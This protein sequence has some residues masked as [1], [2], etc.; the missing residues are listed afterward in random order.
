ME[1]HNGES[2]GIIKLKWHDQECPAIR[3]CAELC[4]PSPLKQTRAA[5]CIWKAKEGHAKLKTMFC[6]CCCCCCRSFC[7]CFCCCCPLLELGKGIRYSPPPSPNNSS[8]FHTNFPDNIITVLEH[9]HELF[10]V[11]HDGFYPGLDVRPSSLIF[12][13]FLNPGNF[14]ICIFSNLLEHFS[15][16]KRAN[17]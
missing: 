4:C 17:L 16:G 9:L 14:G 12:V 1:L 5:R 3:Q 10:F 11:H 6:C 7:C 15:V 13:F 2:K 8:N